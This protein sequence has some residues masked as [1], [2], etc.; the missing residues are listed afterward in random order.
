MSSLM[1]GL[2]LDTIE[3]VR[4]VGELFIYHFARAAREM[5]LLAADPGFGRNT[6]KDLGQNRLHFGTLCVLLLCSNNY[7]FRVWTY[8]EL[9]HSREAIIVWHNISMPYYDFVRLIDVLGTQE[10]LLSWLPEAA[11]DRTLRFLDDLLTPSLFP[12]PIT[13]PGGF[14]IRP[15]DLIHILGQRRCKVAHDRIFG[16]YGCFRKEVRDRIEV[17]YSLTLERLSQSIAETQ[18]AHTGLMFLPEPGPPG[19]SDHYLKL[20][21][22]VPDYIHPLSKTRTLGRSIGPLTTVP[23]QFEVMGSI[24]STQGLCIAKVRQSIPCLANH[25]LLAQSDPISTASMI[26]QSLSQLG[27]Q[28]VSCAMN[29][30]IKIWKSQGRPE[31]VRPEEYVKDQPQ[32]PG[33]DQPSEYPSFW[34]EKHHFLVSYLSD[35][36]CTD[37]MDR[38]FFKCEPSEWYRLLRSE[39]VDSS[40]LNHDFG[41][42]PNLLEEGDEIC[43]LPSSRTGLVLRRVCPH[44]H[45]LIGEAWMIDFENDALVQY[46]LQKGSLQTFAIR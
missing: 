38:S 33:S 42:G 12:H 15:I 7:W 41:V 45:A 30:L 35:L 32:G 9:F 18:M 44:F 29:C 10:D 2:E 1:E 28:D 24:L 13:K 21:S 8:Q 20:P 11:N 5:V 4:E 22:W 26:Y 39:H 46:V 6:L 27:I 25:R 43:F 23:P 34:G 31:W 40:D 14:L 37:L 19:L 36:V 3:I 17:D 16:F